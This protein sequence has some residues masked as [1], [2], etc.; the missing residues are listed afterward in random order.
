MKLLHLL[1]FAFQIGL[2]S[3]QCM[4]AYR[5][6][7]KQ[8]PQAPSGYSNNENFNWENNDLCLTAVRN[9]DTTGI[10]DTL[11]IR[12]WKDTAWVSYPKL[13]L[14]NDPSYTMLHIKNR[15]IITGFY[16][17]YNTVNA[18]SGYRYSLLE[19]RN[20]VWDSVPG[21][22]V[23]DSAIYNI[24]YTSTQNAIYRIN[25]KV[26]KNSFNN[27][28]HTVGDISIYDTTSGSFRKMCDYITY[29]TVRIKGG[30]NRLLICGVDTVDGQKTFGFAYIDNNVVYRNSD[31]RF[32]N[33]D[34]Y[35][36]D[37]TDD[38]IY[39][40]PYAGTPV[41][42]EYS[43]KF[44]GSR[45]SSTIPLS[46]TG[47]RGVY[48]GK[49]V[50][51]SYDADNNQYVNVLCRNETQWKTIV[52]R[53]G[54]GNHLFARSGF[55]QYNYSQRKMI[56]LDQGSLIQGYAFLDIDSNCVR[57]TVTE[58]LVKDQLVSAT[59]LDY[60]VSALTDKNGHYELFVVP[61]TYRLYGPVNK[62]YCGQDTVMVSGL[63]STS[64]KNLPL[65]RPGFHDLKAR[66]LNGSRARW[67]DVVTYTAL[68]ENLGEPCDSAYFEFNTDGKLTIVSADS[69]VKIS[70]SKASGKLEN[71]TYFDKR[72]IHVNVWIDTANTKPDS[73]ICTNLLAYLY[74]Q[75]KDSTNN[76]DTMC[77]R[78][79]YSYDPNH[80]TCNRDTIPVEVSTPL[81]YTI[82]FQNEG[83]DDAHD[84]VITDVI[85]SALDMESFHIIGASHPY[86]YTINGN[87]LTITFKN[88]YLKPKK[89]NEPLS[90]GL[91]KYAISTTT[92][93]KNRTL[94]RNTAYI[95]FDLNK[96]V[97]T[98]TSIV[99]VSDGSP[100]NSIA[101]IQAKQAGLSVYPNPVKNELHIITN[102]EDD[103]YIYNFEGRQM[104]VLQP[105]NG[106]ATVSTTEWAP[107]VYML[108]CGQTYSK[109]VKE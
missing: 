31:S 80:K 29:N 18:P 79:V 67:N 32:A 49:I 107:G 75:D 109:V 27:Y 69:F 39:T 30:I 73:I 97:I 42:M 62:T 9:R 33:N 25:Y 89:T 20:G 70:G 6:M 87:L 96:P 63:N 8:P 3:S 86:T 82:E 50:F 23:S 54:W 1:F 56:V 2:L 88:I 105:E 41:I 85:S 99:F 37:L 104:T 55:Y 45:T 46:A 77:Q 83:N 59:T 103:I 40:I 34:Y 4:P 71:L 26:V 74:A 100:V 92:G 72:L 48:D 90:K 98:N 43:N 58:P 14:R 35:Y 60:T 91:F 52:N 10:A 102:I 61:G 44:L 16:K 5:T 106:V 28:Y 7:P 95:Y 13:F 81:D 17:Q 78:V 15:T 64:K 68:V 22:L 47:G 93:L 94:I 101:D 19:F 84:V 108:R 21:S 66:L 51:V 12:H 76:V 36:L 65:L 53:S 11:I 38:H 24:R 57:D